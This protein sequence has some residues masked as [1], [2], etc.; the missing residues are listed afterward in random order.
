MTGTHIVERTIQTEADV[1]MHHDG[2]EEQVV[3][4]DS[5]MSQDP[6][7]VVLEGQYLTEVA[8][9][10][11][12]VERQPSVSIHYPTVIN[13]FSIACGIC[14]ENA[15][16]YPVRVSGGHMEYRFLFLPGLKGLQDHVAHD[17]PDL[18]EL[19]LEQVRVSAFKIPVS[20][21]DTV[22]MSRGQDP[23]FP[24]EKRQGVKY[25]HS[26]RDRFPTVVLGGDGKFFEIRC[27]RCGQ[28]GSYSKRGDAAFFKGLPGLAC[29]ARQKCY[30][31]LDLSDLDA[32]ALCERRPIDIAVAHRILTGVEFEFEVE[33]DVGSR[34]T[35]HRRSD[36]SDSSADGDSC[37][38]SSDS[39]ED[40]MSDS[41]FETSSIQDGFTRRSST[42]ANKRQDHNPTPVPSTTG[43]GVELPTRPTSQ[44]PAAPGT[45]PYSITSNAHA[46]P[47]QSNAAVHSLT[48]FTAVNFGKHRQDN[49]GGDIPKR[50]S[51]LET[52]RMDGQ[53]FA[54]SVDDEEEPEPITAPTGGS[55]GRVSH[56][57]ALAINAKSVGA[58]RSAPLYS[59]SCG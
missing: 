26:I 52:E 23:L 14:L 13:G 56:E 42:R 32:W 21:A 20:N 24:I 30:L 11:F 51:T 43:S 2:E 18:G 34:C 39:S 6:G 44:P 49:V 27:P 31:D 40:D 59:D 25:L 37:D 5:I 55:H 8:D 28:N 1:L 46:A 19:S 29:H 58:S 57:A 50:R 22:R 4:S 3:L 47:Q 35:C 41:D 15:E 36:E 7:A 33:L 53:R 48:S 45:R 17:Q 12:G 54:V 10:V 38:S 9:A 16:S